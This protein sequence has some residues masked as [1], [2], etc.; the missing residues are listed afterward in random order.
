MFKL[1][2]DSISWRKRGLNITYELGF[3]KRRLIDKIITSN[4]EVSRPEQKTFTYTEALYL[5]QE[6]LDQEGKQ[7]QEGESLLRGHALFRDFVKHLLYRN[8]ANYDSMILL[9]GSKGEGKSSD[10]I[11]M[12]REWCRIIGIR[13]NPERHIAYSNADV[14]RK[15]DELNK[16]EPLICLSGDTEIKIF[17]DN[18]I[19]YIKIKELDGQ[20]NL[21]V[22]AYNI[23]NKKQDIQVA[24]K[25]IKTGTDDVYEI[26][27]EDGVKIKATKNHLFLT[28]NGYKKLCDLKE[29][30]DLIMDN[31][32]YLNCVVCNKQ[33]K[34]TGLTQKY[35]SQECFYKRLRTKR[36]QKRI[37]KANICIMCQKIFYFGHR[38][39]CCSDECQKAYDIKKHNSKKDIVKIYQ[40]EYREK[41]KEEL[42]IK[43]LERVMKDYE[44]YKR[45]KRLHRQQNRNKA[46][47]KLREYYAKNKDKTQ[48][49]NKVW[50]D[51][52]KDWM[53]E[54]RRRYHNKKHKTDYQYRLK[55]N[56]RSR[57]Y[58]AI[59]YNIDKKIN[60]SIDYC[61][62]DFI[63]LQQYLEKQFTDGMSWE[64][65]GSYWSI[66]HIIPCFKF[67]LT[68]EEGIKKCFHYTNLRPLKCYDNCIRG[69]KDYWEYKN[70]NKAY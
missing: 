35:C 39:C 3:G 52:N 37:K 49:A 2:R 9:T 57:L 47:Q 14:M 31:K 5:I 21:K 1:Y 43:A 40:K 36:K 59:K 7:Y 58:H 8:L 51:K 45:K 65:Y 61:G 10:A 30:D 42:K 13:F 4:W 29:D 44:E 23:E 48:K 11:V 18:K 15:I 68:K 22:F 26:E 66:D 63:F 50:K 53:K 56:I 28:T 24:D 70:E 60:S 25:C 46:N 19:K 6:V 41:N 20:K 38:K 55:R 64:N 32:K 16:F 54:Y 34:R 17:V 62:C 69:L 67:D 27:L 12:A 33:Y